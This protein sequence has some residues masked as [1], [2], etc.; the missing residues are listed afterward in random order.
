MLDLTKP[1]RERDSKRPCILLSCDDLVVTWAA[2]NGRGNGAQRWHV[3][4]DYQ[5][6][7]DGSLENVPEKRT[8]DVWVNVYDGILPSYRTKEDAD[9]CAIEPRIACL[10]VVRE[11]EEG[12][13][14]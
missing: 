5:E 3:Y 10:H 12:E 4:W 7:I 14:L 2:D 13:G 11:Y 1:L 6:R 8:L 9:R